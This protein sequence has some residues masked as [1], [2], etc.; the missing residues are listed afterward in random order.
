MSERLCDGCGKALAADE[1]VYVS[2]N[3]HEP[4]SV[5]CGDC[6]KVADK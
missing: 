1:P 3:P 6:E 2:T 5:L 4:S